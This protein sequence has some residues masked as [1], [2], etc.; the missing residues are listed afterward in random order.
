MRRRSQSYVP[1]Q[2]YHER[3]VATV[4]PRQV[5]W[6]GGARA[7]WEQWAQQGGASST[8]SVKARAPG[9]GL[10]SDHRRAPRGHLWEEGDMEK[11][12][13]REKI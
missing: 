2:K 5:W 1:R 7:Q 3:H 10:G 9:Q 6:E 4:A 13:H 8:S 11:S 12:G